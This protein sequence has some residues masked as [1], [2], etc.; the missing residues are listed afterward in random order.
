MKIATL[1]LGHQVLRPKHVPRDLL[2]ALLALDTNVLFLTEYVETPEYDAAL[3]ACWPHVLASEQV[4]YGAS[5]ARVANQVVALSRWPMSPRP[6][7]P[8]LPDVH[9][10]SNFLSVEVRERVFTGLRAPAYPSAAMWYLYWEELRARLDGDV[11]IGDFNVDPRRA[12]K[13]DRV[14]PEGWRVVTPS[15]GVSYRSTRNGTESVVDH[16]LV[17]PGVK[18]VAAE[19]RPEFLG[20]WGLDHCP[21]VIEVTFPE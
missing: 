12:R 18:V 7:L 13:R 4:Q 11:V 10:S 2:D 6:G 1:N 3:R 20:R 9:A 15:G 17:R 8:P 19:Y 5:K 21:L 16:A 14:L